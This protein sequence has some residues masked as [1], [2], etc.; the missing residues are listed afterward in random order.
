MR[1]AFQRIAAEFNQAKEEP[2]A[3]H[4]IAQFIRGEARDQVKAA[5]SADYESLLVTGSPGAG[6]WATVPWIAVFDPAVTDSATRGYYLVYLFSADMQRVYLSLNQ[7]T[8]EAHEEFKAGYALEL[9]RRAALM[10]DRLPEHQGRFSAD[11]IDLASTAFLPRGY[12][13]GHAFGANYPL[14]NLPSQAELNEDLND[15]V[16]LY[17]LL[18]SR[19]GVQP[20]DSANDEEDLGDNASIP[21][22]KRYR[23]HRSIER[24]P[25][26][27]RK[28]KKALGYICQGCEFDFES[29]YGPAGHTYIEAHHLTPL[30][31]LPEDK[32]VELDPRKDFAVL[33]ANCHRMMH[34][35]DGP[36]TVDELRALHRVPEFRDQ[37]VELLSTNSARRSTDE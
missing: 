34:R 27:A 20:S 10:R 32:P 15:I 9:Q 4:P 7:G 23:Q 14:A 12:E 5:L 19:N 22:K 3:N 11:E 33:C 25:S 6:N 30:S 17:L 18:R 31:E 2:L 1:E 28:A 16:R 21:E 29:I 35:K 24:N 37:L 26:A 8:T 13:A 36:R